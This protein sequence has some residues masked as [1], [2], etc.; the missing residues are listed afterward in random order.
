MPAR[1]ASYDC[2]RK[3]LA[4][5]SREDGRVART[6]FEMRTAAAAAAVVS[7]L[8]P[9]DISAILVHDSRF[10][11]DRLDSG[12][13][14]LIKVI[15]S[16]PPAVSR[17]KKLCRRADASGIYAIGRATRKRKKKHKFRLEPTTTRN[18]KGSPGRRE[19]GYTD[20]KSK[21][22]HRDTSKISRLHRRS[23]INFA[24]TNNVYVSGKMAGRRSR[25]PL[26]RKGAPAM[27]CSG[28]APS[29]NQMS[30]V[31]TLIRSTR[32]YLFPAT[33][34]SLAINPFSSPAPPSPQ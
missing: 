33:L 30:S 6:I 7:R 13:G 12:N 19:D 14:D 27:R 21:S 18:G 24:N 15:A 2:R 26:S 3:L 10:H 8:S 9:P 29:P 20:Q 4:H 25:R 32:I 11:Y 34:V 1:R 16:L 5:R 22:Q 23:P 31:V 28:S 17:L